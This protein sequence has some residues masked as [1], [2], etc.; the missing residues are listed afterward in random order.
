MSSGQAIWS[1]ADALC[2][3]TAKTNPDEDVSY[4]KSSAT[5]LHLLGWEFPDTVML[6]TKEGTLYVL[7]T[8]KKV[9]LLEKA[10]EKSSSDDGGI[11]VK[12]LAVSLWGVC[13]VA[14]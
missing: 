11:K 1:E 7:A 12:L 13:L 4:V 9:S 2:I 8:A 6:F 5:C 3:P 10:A 14:T